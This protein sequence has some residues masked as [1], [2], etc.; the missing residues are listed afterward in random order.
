LWEIFA[1]LTSGAVLV[2]AHPEGGYDPAYLVD[3]LHAE[4]VTV[5]HFVPSILALIA[6]NPR[7]STCDSIRLL[8]VG[9]EAFS[10]N[11]YEQV[12]TTLPA[13]IIYN[14]YGPTEASIDA[15]AYRC[16]SQ[17]I[18]GDRVPIGEPISG[19]VVRILDADGSPVEDGTA[20]ELHIGGIG[21]AHGYVDEPDLTAAR[22]LVTDDTESPTPFFRTGDVVRVRTDDGLVEFLGRTDEQVKIRG[23]RIEPAELVTALLDHPVVR[24]AIALPLSDH[25]S[26][27]TA[28]V[29]F[30]AAEESV[31]TPE[32][33]RSFVAQL[34]PPS[35]RPRAVVIVA[36]FPRL[37]SGKVD[38]PRLTELYRP[39]EAEV[40]AGDG[41]TDTLVR[42]ADIWSDVLSIPRP[43]PDADFFELGGHSL[44]AVQVVSRIEQ[45]LN[46]VVPLQ[47]MFETASLAALGEAVTELRSAVLQP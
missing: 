3:L 18:N 26:G 39:P 10:A 22:F 1:T 20:G 31:V 8:L 16:A 44:M 32:E 47:I 6:G 5:A 43:R 35:M 15:T 4:A 41:G 36:E 25:D 42:L 46:V 23:V 30:A 19:T 14:Q 28:L 7:L 40:W 38:R 9:G 37:P 27:E 11:L 34:L 29:A 24:D 13:A 45:E 33:L 21:V 12:A 17:R 2:I